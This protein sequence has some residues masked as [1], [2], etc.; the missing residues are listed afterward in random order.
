MHKEGAAFR[1][2][3]NCFAIAVSLGLQ[4]GVPLDEYVDAFVF[5][6]FDP[7]GSCDHPNIKFATS[8][9]DYMF[10]VLG[11]EYLGRTDFVQVKPADQDEDEERV[12]ERIARKDLPPEDSDLDG[13]RAEAAPAGRGGTATE[14]GSAIS[15]QARLAM[16]DA[17]FCDH[18]GHLAVRNGSCYKCLNCGNSMG[19]S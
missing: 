4:H 10:R 13:P 17:P 19:C 2:I 15:M 12:L 9:V 6:R 5:T 1:S 3:M 14:P 11:M 16:E 8:V 7:Q 18:C